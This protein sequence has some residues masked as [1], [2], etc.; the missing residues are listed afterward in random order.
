MQQT[1]IVWVLIFTECDGGK[2]GPDCNKK[3]GN[4]AQNGQCHHINGSCMN[5]CDPGYYGT[6]CSKSKLCAD[7]TGSCNGGCKNGWTGEQCLEGTVI[8]I[9][10]NKTNESIINILLISMRFKL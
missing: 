1:K 2:Y 8:L 4:C 10:T 5:G 3:C 6:Y 9:Q 7:I